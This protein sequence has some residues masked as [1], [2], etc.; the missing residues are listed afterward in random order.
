MKNLEQTRRDFL[1]MTGKGVLGAAALTAIPAIMKPAF[2]EAASDV[3]APAYP[4]AYV[5]VDKE[6]V[7]KHAY[8]SFYKQGGCCAGVVC[9]IL[10]TMAAD[11]G[12]PYNQIN[13]A[14]FADGAGGYGAGSLCG[15]LGG[16][17]AVIG[18]FCTA[19]D[20]R[21]IRDELFTWYK[22]EPFP[23]YQP[24][25][26]SIT[27]VSNSIQCV[28]SVGIYMKATG[29]AMGDP[30]RKARCAGVTAQVAAKTVE[31]LN[32]HF[33]LEAAATPTDDAAAAATLGPNEYIGVGKSEIGGDVKVKVTM[34]GD[35]IAK[36]DVLEQHETSGVSDP[37]FA[38]IPDAIIAAQSTQVDTVSGATKTSEALIA[39][40]NDALSQVKK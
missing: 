25:M 28:D 30:G 6:A 21:A 3:T 1:R 33:G 10:D 17:C 13:G 18:L 2:G 14:M 26:E 40:V 16:A 36:I 7:M 29:Y 27:T 32:V 8:E 24:E 19:D 9:G 38:Q 12:Y 23:G 20:A 4:W 15:S 5:Q 11:H 31:L 34:D 39:A 22:A 37:A 35:K